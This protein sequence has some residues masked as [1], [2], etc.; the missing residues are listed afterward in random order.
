MLPYAPARPA[1]PEDDGDMGTRDQDQDDVAEPVLAALR[2]LVDDL[3]ARRH[4]IGELRRCVAV[5][6]AG[7]CP[8]HPKF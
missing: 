7:R 2:A 1:G 5:A 6:T 3:A 4:A 8:R